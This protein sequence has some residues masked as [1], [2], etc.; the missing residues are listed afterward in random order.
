ME[1]FFRQGQ[2]G[3]AKRLLK[4]LLRDLELEFKNQ[5]S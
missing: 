3:G 2:A 1:M 5:V 4:S